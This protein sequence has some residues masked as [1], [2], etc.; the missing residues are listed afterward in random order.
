MADPILLDD[1]KV[2]LGGYD[3]TGSVNRVNVR[4]ARAELGSQRMGDAAACYSPGLVQIDAEFGGFWEA[5]A[6]SVD[7]LIA[8]SRLV[9]LD[10]TSW[11]LTFCPPVSGT[12]GSSGGLAYTVQGAQYS[13][14]FGAAHGELIPFSVRTRARTG[15]LSRQTILLPKA[16]VSATTTGTGRQLGAVAATQ[17]L[18]TVLHVFAVT[19]G[20]WTLTIESDDNSGF[21]SATTRQ[22][23][24]GAT[25]LTRQVISTA[26]AISD[27]YYRAVLTKSGGTSC[28]AAVA[29]SIEPL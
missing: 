28:S 26:G 23:F 13:F 29:T 10:A 22:T 1:C 24:T 21:T 2:W 15:G 20:T 11:P 25:G 18:V 17:Q 7:E 12:A 5:G 19:G 16:T 27:D 9:T 14:D 4:G 8:G 6:G 3:F